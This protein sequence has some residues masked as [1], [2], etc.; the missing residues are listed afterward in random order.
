M[1]NI[2]E[3]TDDFEIEDEPLKST[4]KF[5]SRK[6]V[7]CIDISDE[8]YM[9]MKATANGGIKDPH[10]YN[11][12]RLEIV[13]RYLKRYVATNQLIGNDEDE[14]AIIL[15]TDVAIWSLDFTSNRTIFNTKIDAISLDSLRNYNDFDTQSLADTLKAHLNVQNSNFYYH[16]ILIY[17]RSTVIPA[18]FR[19]NAFQN[20]RKRTNFMLDVLFLHNGLA[21]SKLMQ[22]V[23]DFWSELD[24][25]NRPGWYYES[26]LFSGKE[27][28]AIALSQL[29]GHPACRGHQDRIN[30]TL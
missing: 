14:Y 24:D 3:I 28:V 19:D 2:I 17:S 4:S 6:I 5:Q 8:M 10:L 11:S 20:L 13:Q 23:Y 22:S 27:K 9:T 29:I 30:N 18:A 7:F 25:D 1:N 12:P 26:N 16:T 15:L 21:A